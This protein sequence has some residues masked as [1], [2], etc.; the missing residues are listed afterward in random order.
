MAEPSDMTAWPVEDIPDGDKLFMRVHRNWCPGGDL[1]PGVFRDHGG[2]M[3]TDWE[4]YSTPQEA[5]DPGPLDR[6]AAGGTGLAG[7]AVHGILGEEASFQAKHRTVSRVEA[8]SF[9]GDRLAQDL[10]DRHVETADL[11]RREG[12]G[13]AF[14]V[15]PR[16]KEDLVRVDV[17]DPRED[18]LV[19]Q[20]RLD[21]ARR[22]R[23]GASELFAMD[24]ER[25]GTV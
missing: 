19:H 3:S 10:P 17:P 6:L 16:A 22:F 12:R 25:V 21:R 13:T 4:R 20:G 15:D 11:G 18:L 1:S 9:R 2:G 7:A 23:E 24:F 14:G 8:R 5:R